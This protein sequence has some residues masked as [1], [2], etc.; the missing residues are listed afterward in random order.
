MLVGKLARESLLARLRLHVR[1]N[2]VPHAVG[3][4]AVAGLA[5]IVGVERLAPGVGEFVA[6][7]LVDVDRQ[8]AEEAFVA[9]I[10]VGLG[11]S[12]AGSSQGGN[13]E[14][15][16]QLGHCRSPLFVSNRSRGERLMGSLRS[17]PQTL[18]YRLG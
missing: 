12:R 14:R 7:H 9:G 6:A 4:E 18:K 5:G 11:E 17:C 15:S 2:V 8:F 1:E 10:T 16:K 3:R 13:G